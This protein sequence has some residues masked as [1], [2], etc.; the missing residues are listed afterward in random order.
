EQFGDVGPGTMHR[1][2]QLFGVAPT[3]PQPTTTGQQPPTTTGEK[4]PTTTPGT[5]LPTL[6][7]RPP[8]RPQGQPLPGTST[9]PN[10]EQPNAT[11]RAVDPGPAVEEL[12]QKLRGLAAIFPIVAARASQGTPGVYDLDTARAVILFKRLIGQD[13]STATVDAA[14]WRELDRLSP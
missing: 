10:V 13:H 14:T 12:Q 8:G 9:H 4:P 2:D 11:P 5:E 3:G 1:L 6:T 7:G